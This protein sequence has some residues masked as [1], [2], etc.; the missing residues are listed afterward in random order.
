MTPSLARPRGRAPLTAGLVVA[1]LAALLGGCSK[2]PGVIA[3]VNQQTI[4]VSQFNEVA[5]GNLQ[6]LAGPPDSAKARL[7]KDLVDRELLVQGARAAGLDGTPEFGDFRRRTEEQLIRE[8]LYQQLLGGPFPVSDAEVRELHGRRAQATRAR[9]IFT[10]DESAI[11]EAEKALARGDDFAT[12]ADRF[13]PSGQVPPGGD[14]GFLQSG[15][16]LSPLD[17]LVR[18]GEPGRVYG[19]IAAAS[20]GWFIVRIEERRPESQPPLDE[21][22]AQLGEML[23]QRKQRVAMSRVI[24]QLSAEHEVVVLPGAAQLLSGRLRPVPGAEAVPRTPPPPAEDERPLVLA[25]HRDGAYTLG[26]AYDDLIGGA[27]R[28]DFAMIPSVERWLRSQTIERA[29]LSEARKRRLADEPGVQRRIRER[30]NNYLLDGYYQLQVLARI[31][32]GPG[33][34]REAYERYRTALVRLRSARVMSVT[35][36]DSAEAATLAALAARA[37]SLREAAVTAA[38]AA[39]V[40]EETLAFPAESPLWT[41]LEPQ[42]AGMR[43]GEIA[44]PIPTESGWL[45]LQLREKREDAPSF[46]SLPPATVAQLQGVA[47]EIKREA[48][49]QV[50]TDSLRQVF[51]PVIYEQRL[52]RLPWPPAPAA[53]PGS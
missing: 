12:V 3:R 42:L 10:H 14:V 50:L 17:D 37:P 39:R 11:R 13:N 33:D 6:M 4:T 23:R 19:P 53:T 51:T 38:A 29:A 40:R 22:R 49:L 20:E 43:P 34:F 16:L 18:T 47:T 24:E 21:A 36:A 15:A 48:R 5:L 8:A 25:R 46:E 30:L 44:G 9:L 2:D 1:A 41:Q 26:E 32:I 28:I 31:S 27:G 52:R 35:L 45:I 7:L